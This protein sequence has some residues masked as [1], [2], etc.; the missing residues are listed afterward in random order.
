MKT[1]LASVAIA[2][3]FIGCGSS[4]P[5]PAAQPAAQ[6]QPAAPV[7][8]GS[9]FSKV[10]LQMGFKQVTDLIGEPN[11]MAIRRTGKTWMPFYYGSDRAR[12]VA[13]YKG[14]GRLEFNMANRLVEIIPDESE[15]GYQ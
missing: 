8:A 14:E 9:K 15:D 3:M 11:D 2:A 5:K 10:A 7:K 1:V 12:R 13:Y 4:E 6:A